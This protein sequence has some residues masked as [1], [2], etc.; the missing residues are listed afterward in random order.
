MLS[1]LWDAYII[2]SVMFT[3]AVLV[4]CVVMTVKFHK[5]YKDLFK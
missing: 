4:G 1:L 5:L 3:T 2:A